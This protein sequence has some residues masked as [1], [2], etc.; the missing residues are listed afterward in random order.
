MPASVIET[1]RLRLRPFAPADLDDLHRLFTAPGVRRY[2]LDDQ[3]MPR[4]WVAEEIASSAERFATN[5]GG[6]W[7][8]FPKGEEKL[9]GACGYRF[10]HDPP[11]LQL[12]YALAPTHWGTGLAT[13]AARA[14]IRYGFEQL[15]LDRIVAATDPP[16]AASV[17]VMERCGLTYDKRATAGGLDTIFYS[18]GRGDFRPDDAPYAV[19]PL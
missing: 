9:I 4:E 13:E 15:G 16:N 19:R 1:A 7:S 11:E 5:G 14:M 18:L 6:L 2:L 3:V 8:L 12:L 17:R 10:F